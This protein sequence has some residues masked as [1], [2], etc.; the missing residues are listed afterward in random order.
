MDT[1]AAAVVVGFV[2]LPIWAFR[3]YEAHVSR[4]VIEAV[5][6]QRVEYGHKS[7]TPSAGPRL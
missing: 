6:K 7:Q 2:G 5:R 1:I 4:K 3:I